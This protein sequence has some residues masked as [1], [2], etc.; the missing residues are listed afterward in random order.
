MQIKIYLYSNK[1]IMPTKYKILNESF[2]ETPYFDYIT[3]YGPFYVFSTVEAHENLWQ[4]LI[5]PSMYH[6]A[7]SE[8]I[9]YGDIVKFPSKYIYQWMG[10]IM[11]NTAI[12]RTTTEIAGHAQ[13]FPDEDFFDYYF[14]DETGKDSNGITWDEWK[15]QHGYEDD[16]YESITEYLNERG[17]YD[18]LTLPDGSDAWSD[19]GLEPIENLIIQYKEN[20]SPKDTLILIN[21]ILDV[22]HQR[23]DLA[24]IFIEGGSK[25]LNKISYNES[26]SKN[27]TIILSESQFNTLLNII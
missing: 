7:L 15:E 3:E 14:N 25:S 13:Y 22:Y 20:M 17:F 18:D 5:N 19:F 23:G 10:I 12:L 1:N 27:K 24:S 4:P 8:L 16:D 26:K 6:K 21:K 9:K 11:K 2:D